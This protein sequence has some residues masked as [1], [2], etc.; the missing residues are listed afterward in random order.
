MAGEVDTIE[1]LQGRHID[2]VINKIKEQAIQRAVQSGARAGQ[3]P[4]IKMP[5]NV[6]M[7]M[8]LV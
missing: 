4:S 3:S 1:I 2:D 8:D 7:N 5:T 6:L